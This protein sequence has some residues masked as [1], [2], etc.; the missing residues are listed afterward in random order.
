MR[1]LLSFCISLCFATSAEAYVPQ[2]VVQE[3]LHDITTIIDPEYAQGF[4]GTLS[5]FPHTYEIHAKDSFVLFAEIRVPE[6][7]ASKNTVSG[8]VIKEQKKG[9]VEEITRFL[10]E[11]ALWETQY[12]YLIGEKYRE[13]AVFEK[14]LG[15]GTYRIEVHTPDNREKYMLMVGKQDRKD[16]GYFELIGRIADVKE[17]YGTSV[18]WIIVS[19]YVYVPI[20]I[21]C[22]VALG[23]LWYRRRVA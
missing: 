13:G 11:D 16:V 7:E 18:L 9:R 8:I 20:L 19:P 2:V 12:D 15:P 6:L 23:Y 17:F 22:I 4:F 21:I 5:D 14:E 3:S 1:F 10:A